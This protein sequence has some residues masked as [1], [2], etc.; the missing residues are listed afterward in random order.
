MRRVDV[1]PLGVPLE[2]PSGVF[3]KN[4]SEVL[5]VPSSGVAAAEQDAERVAVSRAPTSLAPTW[6]RRGRD[7]IYTNSWAPWSSHAS[8]QPCDLLFSGSIGRATRNIGYAT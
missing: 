8:A 6:S 4:C 2:R 7:I 1:K 3:S 5:I